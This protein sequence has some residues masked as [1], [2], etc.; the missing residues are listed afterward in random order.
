MVDENALVI[1]LYSKKEELERILL[2]SESDEEL[3]MGSIPYVPVLIV[4]T[5]SEMP[6]TMESESRKRSDY[7]NKRRRQKC[8]FYPFYHR[9]R[10]TSRR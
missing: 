4:I 8:S 1:V 10:Q 7:R 2:Q 6:V 3:A 5:E 9:Q